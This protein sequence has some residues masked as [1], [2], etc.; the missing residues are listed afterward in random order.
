[1]AERVLQIGTRK[2]TKVIC[3]D[4]PELS[5]DP[6]GACHNYEV[7]SADGVASAVPSQLLAKLHFQ[8]GPV[9]EVGVNGCFHEDLLAI[10][11]D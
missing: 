10:V 1:M 9:K 3:T 5:L 4:E 8:N 2:H 6:G 11:I 7:V